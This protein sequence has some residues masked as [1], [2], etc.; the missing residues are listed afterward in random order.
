[1]YGE[2][3]VGSESGVGSGRCTRSVELAKLNGQLNVRVAAVAVEL[4]ATCSCNMRLP[5]AFA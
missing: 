2:S 4:L 3:R 1:M 5:I